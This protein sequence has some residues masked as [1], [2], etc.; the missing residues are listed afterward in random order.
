M[1]FSNLEINYTDI[2]QSK[3]NIDI[4]T[5]SNLFSWNGQFSPQLIEALLDKY[6]NYGDNV[7][8]PFLGSGTT[9]CES[10]RKGLSAYGVELNP[11]AYYMAKCYELCCVDMDK[12][13]KLVMDIEN[14]LLPIDNSNKILPIL[15]SAIHFS[16]DDIKNTLSLLLVL[17]DLFNNNLSVDLL[18]TKWKK[19]KE[20]IITLPVTQNKIIAVQ[21]DT[22]HTDFQDDLMDLVIT[23]PPY[24]NVFNYHQ[25]YRRSV[26]E[27][28]YNVLHIAKQE[29]GSNRRNRGNRFLT[30]IEYCIDMALA[31]REMVRV[32]RPGAHFILIVG[33]ESNVLGLSFYN[34]ELIYSICSEIFGLK[35]LMRQERFFKNRFGRQIYEDII[36]FENS[37]TFNP[38]EDMIIEK[39]RKIAVSMLQSKLDSLDKHF[40]NYETLCQAIMNCKSVIK[41][42]EW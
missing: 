40:T 16:G 7:Y 17:L 38:N 19:L 25:K 24:I 13:R 22:R 10:A 20:I 4:K 14:I 36:H 31:I 15:K 41:S 2:P 26:E 11:S 42:E 33:R 6:S 35:Y 37:K 3:L 12:R 29:F 18:I 8:D 27:L 30:V 5:R 1:D 34:S 28:G 9:L 32:S 21:G 39:S 23:S